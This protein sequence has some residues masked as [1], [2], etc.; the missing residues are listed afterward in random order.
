MPDAAEGICYCGNLLILGYIAEN[1]VYVWMTDLKYQ[2]LW[3]HTILSTGIR[4]DEDYPL[5]NRAGQSTMPTIPNL[6]ASAITISSDGRFL[7]VSLSAVPFDIQL[8]DIEQ[9][10]LLSRLEGHVIGAR[11]LSF[12]ANGNRLRSTAWSDLEIKIWDTSTL[13]SVEALPERGFLRL[14]CP[15][16]MTFTLDTAH[17]VS[18]HPISFF[19]GISPDREFGPSRNRRYGRHGASPRT[20]VGPL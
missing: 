3:G 8:W 12:F 4:V 1:Q 6:E 2:L 14:D 11:W 7:A 5:A 9:G 15:C 19:R 10:C 13:V 18:F 17:T 20:V 16:V